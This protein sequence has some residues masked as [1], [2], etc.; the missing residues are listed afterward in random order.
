MVLINWAWVIPTT[1]LAAPVLSSL[2]PM[3][4]PA[5]TLMRAP[6]IAVLWFILHDMSFYC[7]H[8]TLHE[9]P[10]LYKWFHKPHHMC[11]APFAWSSHAT[12]PVEMMLQSIGAMT[13]PL[14]WA[15]LYGLPIYAWWCWLALVQLQGV[16]DHSGYDFPAPFDCFAMLPGFGGTKFHDE[17]HKYFNGNYAAAFSVIDDVMGTRLKRKGASRAD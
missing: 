4:A 14:I 5:P 16:M 15:A 8:R 7:Y 3:S 2:F 10:W 9:V 13:G 6:L 1:I 12:H 17:H 11:T